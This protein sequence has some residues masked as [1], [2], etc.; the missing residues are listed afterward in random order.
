[1]ASTYNLQLLSLNCSVQYE[2]KISYQNIYYLCHFSRFFF[3]KWQV[4]IWC[5][6]SVITVR[7]HV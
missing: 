6:L 1:M 4:L 3:L 2:N 5:F 7:R